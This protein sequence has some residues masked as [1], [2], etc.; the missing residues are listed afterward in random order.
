MAPLR[1]GEAGDVEMVGREFDL[2][3][4]SDV[5]YHDHLY[6]PLLQTLQSLLLGDGEG[7]KM[8]MLM[9]H[10]RRWKKE[11]AFFK[12]AKK[13]FE[14]EVLH[15]DRPCD[16]SRVGVVVYRFAAKRVRKPNVVSGTAKGA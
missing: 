11:A 2:I 5:V 15:V 3:L 14:V 8:A 9:A 13:V 6:E 10:L 4:A 7:S 12:K 16:G 1:W